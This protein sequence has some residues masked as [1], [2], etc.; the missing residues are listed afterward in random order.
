MEDAIVRMLEERKREAGAMPA[1]RRRD[2][3]ERGWSID[4]DKKMEKFFMYGA[5]LPW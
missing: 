1:T 2:D 3:E 4:K 5:F